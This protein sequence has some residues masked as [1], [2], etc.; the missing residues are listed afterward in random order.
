M[1]TLTIPAQINSVLGGSV[2]VDYEKQVIAP[3]TFDP[4]MQTVSG[5]LKLTSTSNPD[6]QEITGS[7]SID[8]ARALLIVEVAQLDFYKRVAM[9]GPQ[10]TAALTIIANA[11]N[12]LEAGLVSLGVI[13]GTQ[14]AG[15]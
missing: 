4:I 8:C 7:L 15:V 9:T 12:A 3:F 1:I 5:R 11:Q 2:L 10:N 14:T 6:M 13:A